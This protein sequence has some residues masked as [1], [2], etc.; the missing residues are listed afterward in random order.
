MFIV[1]FVTIRSFERGLY[2]KNNEF[3]AILQPGRHWFI[4]LLNQ[5]RVDVI[6]QRTPWLNH[7]DLDLIVKA[8]ALQKDA[9]VLDLKDYER[10]LVWID[11]RFDRILD[12]GQYALWTTFRKVH[13]E[14]VDART[15][16]FDHQDLAVILKSPDFYTFIYD[17]SV[18]Y[19]FY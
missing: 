7:A 16:L 6:S 17:F 15:A 2:F 19:V 18:V 14:V 12:A 10:A 9:L 1:S 8:G 5:R 11:G 13:V 4:D 3:R